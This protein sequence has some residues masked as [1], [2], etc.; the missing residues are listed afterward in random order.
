MRVS[1]GTFAYRFVHMPC[2]GCAVRA[3]SVPV[4]TSGRDA[5]SILAE[6]WFTRVSL[7]CSPCGYSRA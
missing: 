5:P 1:S 3:V 6:L 4:L 7:A 2:R